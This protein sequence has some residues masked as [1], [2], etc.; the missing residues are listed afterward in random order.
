M[1]RITAADREDLE[2]LLFR[3]YPNAEWGT[4]FRFGY[5]VTSWGA[6]VTFVKALPPEAGDLDESSRIVEFRARYILRAQQAMEEDEL[7]LGVMH[8]HPE[9]C[10]TGASSLDEDM[11]T[12]FASEFAACGGARPYVSIRIA[13]DDTGRLSFSGELHVGRVV[14]PM[15]EFLTIGNTLERQSAEGY[16][17]ALTKP[18]AD[19][20]LAAS[21]PW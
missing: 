4:F 6:H 19:P 16:C 21:L 1:F 12:Y 2:E 11:D 5:R 13:R 9:G 8:S 3:R 14:I 17:E 20:C 18:G 10:G 15:T 7:G